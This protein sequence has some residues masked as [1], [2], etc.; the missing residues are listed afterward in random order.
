MGLISG[1]T[2]GTA[3]FIITLFMVHMVTWLSR[4]ISSRLFKLILPPVITVGFTGSCLV[5]IH[6]FVGTP[7]ILHT[8]A[9]ALGVAFMFCVY[10]SF[11][12]Q[13]INIITEVQK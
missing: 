7:A 5:A 6:F 11:K 9:P 10:I 12:L 4:C 3:S 2:Q 1:L 8:I 13:S